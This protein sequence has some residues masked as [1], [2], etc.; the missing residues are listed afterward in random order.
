VG[1]PSTERSIE[2]RAAD[3]SDRECR[4]SLNDGLARIE[5]ALLSDE[6]DERHWY[7]HTIY[8]WNIYALYDGQ[9]LPRVADAIRR[10][11]QTA[12]DREIARVQEALA[13]MRD[14]LERVA[15]S[16]R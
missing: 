11:D 16:C 3:R 8:G 7:R 2:C 12:V 15:G 5:Q 4:Q 14:G 9:P 6:N 1:V 10:Q 13:R